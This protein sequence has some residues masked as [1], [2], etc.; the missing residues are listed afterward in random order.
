MKMKMMKN[1]VAVW[2]V[3]VE[4]LTRGGEGALLHEDMRKERRN[5]RFVEYCKSCPGGYYLAAMYMR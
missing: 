1:Y 2:I 5:S 4:G 3:E